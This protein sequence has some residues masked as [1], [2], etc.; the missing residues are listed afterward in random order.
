[1]HLLSLV[2]QVQENLFEVKLFNIVHS[3]P[4]SAKQTS[5]QHLVFAQSDNFLP[6]A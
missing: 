2:G 1:M 6:F 5:M 3:L 4:V